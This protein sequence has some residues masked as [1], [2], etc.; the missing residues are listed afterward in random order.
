[1]AD[2]AQRVRRQLR[3]V[4]RSC[5]DEYRRRFLREPGQ[6]S[7]ENPRGRS[8]IGNAAALRAGKCLVDFVHPEDCRRDRFSD[9]DGTADILFR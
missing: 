2:F 8:A 3:D 5:D 7:A 9:R 4:V 1:M 6:K